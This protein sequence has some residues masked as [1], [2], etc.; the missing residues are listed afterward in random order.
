[1]RVNWDGMGITEE[2][3]V[4]VVPKFGAF[5]CEFAKADVVWVI[6]NAYQAFA[7]MLDVDEFADTPEERSTR[8]R[9]ITSGMNLQ[10]EQQAGDISQPVLSEVMSNNHL[11]R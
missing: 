3:L 10:A 1:V 5:V 9:Y 2:A 8:A 6:G 7:E 4:G 11:P